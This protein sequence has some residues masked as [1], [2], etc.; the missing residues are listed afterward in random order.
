MSEIIGGRGLWVRGYQMLG[1]E[2]YTS[3]CILKIIQDKGQTV[4]W[5]GGGKI[6]GKGRL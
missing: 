3:T 1:G 4:K 2:F 6:G 5:G